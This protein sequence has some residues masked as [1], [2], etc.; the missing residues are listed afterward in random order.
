MRS[1]ASATGAWGARRRRDWPS[2]SRGIPRR[3]SRGGRGTPGAPGVARA[4]PRG[5]EGTRRRRRRRRRGR[6]PRAPVGRSCDR[7]RRRA[8][9][10]PP[11][12][13]GWLPAR[14]A[15][16][17]VARRDASR[18]S[19]VDER[20]ASRRGKNTS[21]ARIASSFLRGFEGGKGPTGQ[22]ERADAKTRTSRG[23][24]GWS[25]PRVAPRIERERPELCTRRP[26][27][28]ASRH[29]RREERRD[30]RGRVYGRR[31]LLAHRRGRASTHSA[32]R[33]QSVE[34]HA[35]LSH[36]GKLDFGV[37]APVA[38]SSASGSA[39]VV[40]DGWRGTPTMRAR[41]TTSVSRRWSSCA[42]RARQ[43]RGATSTSCARRSCAGPAPLSRMA[44]GARAG[45]PPFTTPLA[46]VI[47]RASSSSSRSGADVNRATTAGGATP[48]HRAAFTG[49][50]EVVR[51]ARRGR[52]SRA[53]GCRPRDSA[54]Q[55]ERGGRGGV[56]R[57]AP[58]STR[59]R[60]TSSI[61]EARRPR[62][63]PRTVPLARRSSAS[64][65]RA[66]RSPPRHR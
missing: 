42:A 22:R 12:G 29:G 58:P 43:R 25:S 24:E 14:V 55:G 5:T 47:S 56:R 31:V 37:E 9:A 20:S 66:R 27:R 45:T 1:R 15:N 39:V 35:Y 36:G 13:G 30:G 3:R 33:H 60:S 59:T 23:R 49:R 52:A 2:P 7:R 21:D 4:R 28:A 57:G 17:C 6:G 38:P 41:L 63:A 34:P 62:I 65:S 46:R 16:A 32:A 48:L 53:A 61:V 26:P 64:R 40:R 11:E 44:P 10:C 50:V 18:T 8:R 19:G 54:T 51:A